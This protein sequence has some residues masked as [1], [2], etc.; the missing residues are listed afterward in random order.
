MKGYT[1]QEVQHH[2]TGNDCW[3]VINGNIYNLTKFKKYH[4][5]GEAA[6]LLVAG[7]DA[8]EKFNAFHNKLIQKLIIPFRIAKLIV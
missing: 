2:N 6:I 7:T 3:V 1:M 4:P 5:G 8:S